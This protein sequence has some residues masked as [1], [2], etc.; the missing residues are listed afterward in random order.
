M[1]K[2]G[3]LG[4]LSDNKH[5]CY[6][7]GNGY[8]L[9][10]GKASTVKK[11]MDEWAKQVAIQ[12]KEWQDENLEEKKWENYDGHDTWINPHTRNVIST[13]KL[14]ELFLEQSKNK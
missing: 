12:F 5:D 6:Q 11:A 14:Y 7:E 9:F 13:E 10:D 4:Y 3:I 1:T 8:D 2:E